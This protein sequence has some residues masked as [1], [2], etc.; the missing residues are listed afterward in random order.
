MSLSAKIR[1]LFVEKIG[2]RFFPC[3]YNRFHDPIFDFIKSK[4]PQDFLHKSIYDLGCG[5]GGNTIRIQKVF[6]PKELIACDR[7]KF[8]LRRA[9]KKGFKTQIIDFN[10][11]FPKGEMATFTFSLHHAY[12]KEKT[13]KSVVKNF[14][15]IFICEPYLDLYHWLFDAGHVPTKEKWIEIFN[16]VLKK[17]L[18]YQYKNSLIVFFKQLI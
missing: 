14:K 18:L 2:Y 9:E 7:N 4:I 17:Y 15:Y 10:S 6:Q 12:D 13:L 5:D 3:L 1:E 11:K 16:K 8:M